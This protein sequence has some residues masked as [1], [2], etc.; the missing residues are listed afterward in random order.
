MLVLYGP[1]LH[2]PLVF[3]FNIICIEH[4]ISVDLHKSPGLPCNPLGIEC[5]HSHVTTSSI[6]PQLCWTAFII[7]LNFM[8]SMRATCSIAFRDGMDDFWR[9]QSFAKCEDRLLIIQPNNGR[10][11]KSVIFVSHDRTIK[12]SKVD[13]VELKNHWYGLFFKLLVV[14]HVIN[15]AVYKCDW[16]LLHEQ[17]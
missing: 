16:S 8:H 6:K 14:K 3:L 11:F 15:G 17:N 9:Q 1:K 2:G 7:P 10:S 12:C 13:Q 4:E 5:H